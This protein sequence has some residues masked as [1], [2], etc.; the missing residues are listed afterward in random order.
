MRGWSDAEHSPGN[1]MSAERVK[2]RAESRVAVTVTPVVS[3]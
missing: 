3:E 2:T 1:L